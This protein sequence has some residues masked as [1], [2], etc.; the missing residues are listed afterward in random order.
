[1]DIPNILILISINNQKAFEE[2]YL[3]FYERVFRFAY[4]SLKNEEACREIVSNVFFAIWISRKKLPA[5]KNIE[6][7]LYAVAQN[8]VKRYM[9]SYSNKTNISLDEIPLQYT[10]AKENSPEDKL[11]ETELSKL[12]TKIVNQLPEK[13]RLIFLMKRREGKSSKEIAEI[14]N[15]KESTVRVQ[16]KIAA[17]KILDY[18]R[19]HSPEL[20][21][22][23]LL[24]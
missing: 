4:Y 18:L 5:V 2:F 20:F 6:T 1:M 11:L 16:L 7:Y 22:L 21:F 13:C 3:H 17:S 9:S 19:V 10:V 24:I 8:E 23:Y 14:L 15:I 12:V